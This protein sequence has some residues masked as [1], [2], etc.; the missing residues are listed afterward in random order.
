M[1]DPMIATG[2]SSSQPWNTHPAAQDDPRRIV[3]TAVIGVARRGRCRKQSV[4]GCQNHYHG[5]STLT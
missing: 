5:K 3:F 4:P 1:L 2:G